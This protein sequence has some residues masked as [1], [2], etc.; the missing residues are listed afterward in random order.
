MRIGVM[1]H[2]FR[3]LGPIIMKNNRLKSFFRAIG[4]KS[5]TFTFWG[6]ENGTNLGLDIE[7]LSVQVQSCLKYAKSYYKQATIGPDNK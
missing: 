7:Y 1:G 5:M 2:K 6:P 3:L 4:T